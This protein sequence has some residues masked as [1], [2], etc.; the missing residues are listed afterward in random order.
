MCLRRSSHVNI[1]KHITIKYLSLLC[2]RKCFS[3]EV[4]TDQR[5][6]WLTPIVTDILA[7]FWPSLGFLARLQASAATGD[8]SL[9]DWW[10][11]VVFCLVWTTL[12]A[13]LFLLPRSSYPNI[14]I[15]WIKKV[16]GN[17]IRKPIDSHVDLPDHIYFAVVSYLHLIVLLSGFRIPDCKLC[18]MTPLRG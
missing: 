8:V 13:L 17:F 4:W 18:W 16:H 9:D 12:T 7:A 10:R 11:C 6:R 3:I 14:L 5:C 2:F 1:A 15:C